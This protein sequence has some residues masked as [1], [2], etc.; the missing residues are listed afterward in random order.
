MTIGR[1]HDGGRLGEVRARRGRET[2]LARA[3]E[4]RPILQR[5]RDRGH[6]ILRIPSMPEQHDREVRRLQ[7]RFGLPVLLPEAEGRG[8]GMKQARIGE[9]ADTCGLRGFDDVP[10]LG[11]AA[12]HR[13]RRD[14]QQPIDALEGGRQQVGPRIVGNADLDACASNCLATS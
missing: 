1:Q 6:V 3:A 10:M 14:Q 12:A 9:Q 7:E 13:A 5:W 8:I 11:N 4:H 2:A